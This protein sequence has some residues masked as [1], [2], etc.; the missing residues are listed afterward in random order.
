MAIEERPENTA[1]SAR[2]SVGQHRPLKQQAQLREI[3]CQVTPLLEI[4]AGQS[5]R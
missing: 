2:L 4:I 5:I 3:I 1:I